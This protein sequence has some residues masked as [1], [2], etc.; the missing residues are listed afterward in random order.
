[1]ALLRNSVD[2]FLTI[3]RVLE[4]GSCVVLLKV[5]SSSVQGSS[6]AEEW[7]LVWHWG[8]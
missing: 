2:P 3:T 7:F 4:R 5:Y 1:M 6:L 8:Y